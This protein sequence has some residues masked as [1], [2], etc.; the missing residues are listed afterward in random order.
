M[1][2]INRLVTTKGSVPAQ[3]QG[4]TSTITLTFGDVAENHVG[5]QRIGSMSSEGFSLRDLQSFQN[6]FLKKGAASDL[7]DLVTYADLFDKDQYGIEPA[8]ILV[9]RQGASVLLQTKFDD[10]LSLLF[11]EQEG[12]DVDK[13][14]LMYGRVVNKHA[15]H[16]LCFGEKAQEPEYEKGK[17]R[18]VAYADV[19][20]TQKLKTELELVCG[21]N[22]TCEGNYYYDI[23]K[24][25]IGWHGDSERRRVIGV[26]LGASLPLCYQWFRNRKPIGKRIDI[27]LHHGDIY[28]MSEKAVGTDWK[29]KKIATLRHA[30]GCDKFLR[31]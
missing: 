19:P 21:P 18:V 15:R 29:K 27:D 13:K 30:A 5:M 9:V 4:M 23:K 3:I 28:I 31:L 16:N 12:L 20:I 25:G 7:M 26:R 22:L 17:G 6:A 1:N 14:A 24:C 8:Y 2:L 10:P 11:K